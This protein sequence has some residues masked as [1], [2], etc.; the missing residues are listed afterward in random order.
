MD[1]RLAMNQQC[2]LVAKKANGILSCIKRNTASRSREVILR[3]YSVLAGP[4]V[5]YCIHF[6][7]SQYKKDRDLLERFQWTAT[8]IIKGLEL[9]PY[10]ERPSNLGLFSL[11]KRKLRSDLINVYKYPKCG[12]QR[13]MANLFS[14]VCGDRT[15]GNSHKLEHRK[16]CTNM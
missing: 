14:M 5:E 2:A 16:F 12:S 7:A 4:H 6:W 3:P 8:K 9:L 15:R 11:E 10:E 1:N 13:D